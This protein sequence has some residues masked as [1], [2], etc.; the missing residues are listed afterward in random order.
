MARKLLATLP[1][2]SSSGSHGPKKPGATPGLGLRRT[3]P[4]N[5]WAD[6]RST[7]TGQEDSGQILL[8]SS[9]QGSHLAGKVSDP[10][11]TIDEFTV[12]EEAKQALSKVMV[13]PKDV[14]A[15]RAALVCTHGQ[16]NGRR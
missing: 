11:H 15:L 7:A 1:Q 5:P 14:F 8:E 2:M 3:N 13:P 16:D 9:G 10:A 12:A 4:P 6:S